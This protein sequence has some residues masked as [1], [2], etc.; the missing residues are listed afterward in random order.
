MQYKCNT[1]AI[2]NM[3]G[4]ELKEKLKDCELSLNE[5][6]KRLNM[7]HQLFYQSLKSPDVKTSLLERLCEA[8]NVDMSFFYKYKVRNNN[9]DEIIRSLRQ[10]LEDKD[11]IIA[12]KEELI[13]LLQK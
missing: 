11:I 6:A 7:S 3:K 5:I 8:L 2:Y 12:S 9:K 10:Q 13:Q 4:E 1:F